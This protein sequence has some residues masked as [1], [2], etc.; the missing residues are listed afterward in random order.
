MNNRVF[1]YTIFLFLSLLTVDS[2]AQDR[3][4]LDTKVADALAQMPANDLVHRDRVMA[5]LAGL[6]LQGFQKMT[7]Y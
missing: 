4:T 6:G 1:Q 5:E 7:S 2:F 3:R